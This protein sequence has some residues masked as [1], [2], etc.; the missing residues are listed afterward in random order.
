MNDNERRTDGGIK[1]GKSF[2]TREARADQGCFGIKW[3]RG[4]LLLGLSGGAAVCLIA[5]CAG[6][7]REPDHKQQVHHRPERRPPPEMPPIPVPSAR[8]IFW[9]KIYRSAGDHGKPPSVYI[10]NAA[11]QTVILGP[12]DAEREF[13]TVRNL[14]LVAG[15]N[16]LTLLMVNTGT[17]HPLHILGSCSIHTNAAIMVRNSA[18]VVDGTLRVSGRLDLVRGDIAVN[19]DLLV[20]GSSDAPAEVHVLGGTLIVTNEHHTARLIIGL[21]GNGSFYLDGGTIVADFL[22]VTGKQ[23]NR[24]VFKSGNVIPGCVSITNGGAFTVGDGATLTL[25][26]PCTYFSG[27][28]IISANGTVTGS[29]SIAGN[30]ANY[31]TISAG[32][33]DLTF[34]PFNN[35]P[36]AVTNWGNMYMTNGG[37]LIF[38]E[39]VLDYAPA[40]IRTVSPN[41]QGVGRTIWFR[42]IGGLV[43]T[44]QYKNSLSDINWTDLTSTNGNG[45]DISLTDPAPTGNARFYHIQVTQP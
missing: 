18:L 26:N 19:S 42:S 34:A 22:Q 4:A 20:E 32:Q 13:L 30:V 11:P 27:G 9:E 31:G 12:H 45:L 35:S 41:Q 21:N 37:N 33:S 16:P 6:A 23:S 1:P 17:E 15:T 5:G 7:G 43:H 3:L 39:T 38:K 14:N 29:G 2:E 28:L 25:S 40:S 8:P 24:F 44:L 36:S 10:T